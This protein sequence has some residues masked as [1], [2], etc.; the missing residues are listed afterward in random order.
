MLNK[1]IGLPGIVDCIGVAA[2]VGEVPKIR[3]LFTK[4]KIKLKRISLLDPG[5]KNKCL[6]GMS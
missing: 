5:L 3:V 1:L 6:A 2:G 4:I